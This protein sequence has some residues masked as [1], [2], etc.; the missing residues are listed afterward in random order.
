M[1]LLNTRVQ[2]VQ[3]PFH[4]PPPPDDLL[5][6]YFTSISVYSSPL[7]IMLRIENYHYHPPLFLL[8]LLLL[9]LLQVCCCSVL[10]ISNA[11]FFFN[12]SNVF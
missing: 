5:S 11:I 8:L 7:T 3:C 4:S 6:R 9:L 2:I 10:N 12:I 1:K